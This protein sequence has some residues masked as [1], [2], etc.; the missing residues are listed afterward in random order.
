MNQNKCISNKVSEM[1]SRENKVL[2]VVVP[3]KDRAE[4]TQLGQPKIMCAEIRYTL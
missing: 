3:V 4:T 1:R 2:K